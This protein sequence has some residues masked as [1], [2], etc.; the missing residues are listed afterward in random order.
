METP[1]RNLI[2]RHQSG[3]LARISA[4]LETGRGWENYDYPVSLE[5]VFQ[6]VFDDSL[7]EA[8]QVEPVIDD[9][10][11][12]G[13]FLKLFSGNTNRTRTP[14]LNSLANVRQL[15]V[16][17]RPQKK[18]P[19]PV[20]ELQISLPQTAIVTPEITERLLLALASRTAPSALEI[21]GCEQSI[22]V[23][24]AVQESG[25]EQAES[26]VR[27][28]FAESAVVSKTQ[29]YLASHF[30][31]ENGES[32][33]SLIIDFGLKRDVLRPLNTLRSFDPDP[34]INLIGGMSDLKKGEKCI[35]QVLFQ[36]I[37]EH[38]MERFNCL[39]VDSNGKPR[40]A[41]SAELLAES[42]KKFSRPLLAAIIRL[43]VVA[44]NRE[45]ALQIARN[46]RGMLQAV[47]S[48]NGNEVMALDSAGISIE[49]HIQYFIN[50]LSNRSGM[51]LNVA[52]LA[53][54]AHL[55]S[56]SVKI[57]KLKRDEQ[58]TK[59][60]PVSALGHRLIL[61]EN[62]HN[63]QS[64]QV[65]LSNE[66][67]TRHLHLLGGTGS[68]KSNLL[69]NLIKQDLETGEGLC[70]IDP[71]GDLIDAVI[72]N[73]PENRVNDV[74]L[75]DPSDAEFPI[76]FN[77]LQAN[78]EIEKT[79]LS[80]DLVAA[81][82][83]ISTSWGD[84]MDAV[85]A[86]AVLAIVESR[87]GGTLFDLKR[88]LVE[89]DFRN[90][91]LASVE[92]E[93]IRYFWQNEFPLIGG[94][95]QG[96]ILI[97][98]DAFLRQ[99]LV[100]NIVCQ[101]QTRLDF[102][103]IMD[104][105]KVMLV[106]LSQ[107]IIGTENSHLLGTLLV[108]KFHQIALSRQNTTNRP[109]FAL[110]I[111]EFHNFVVPSMESVLSGIRKYNVG[112]HLSHQEFR[113]LQSRSQEVAASVLSNCYTRICFR[114]SETDAERFSHGFSFFDAKSLQNLSIGEAVA[115]IGGADSDFNLKTSLLPLAEKTVAERRKA[116]ILQNTREKYA[117]Q[118]SEVELEITGQR[119]VS[120]SGVAAQPQSNAAEQSG[121]AVEISGSPETQNADF[122]SKAQSFG[123]S[124]KI[125]VKQGRGGR[126]H[127]E[128]QA[129]ISRMAESYGFSAEI[130]KNVLDGAGSIDVSLERENLKI[131][132]EV[133]VTSTAD[134]ETKNV[135]K[136]FS[137]GYDYAVVVVSNQK[138]IP[139][140]NAKLQSE[141]SRE[142]MDKVKTVG[143]TELL[144]FLRE[145]T[146]PEEI[147]QKKSKKPKGQRLN[148]TEACEFFGVGASTLYRWII[149]GRI[150][151]YRPGREYQFDPLELRLVGRHDFSGKRKASVKLEPLKIEKTTPKSKKQQDTRYRKMLKLE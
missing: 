127:Q 113:Q 22:V 89:R 103:E 87:R 27:A 29:N 108:S 62:L 125:E 13:F 150:P 65:T 74:I 50:R 92:D 137:S 18:L 38:W 63:G 23:Q 128:L 11:H 101:K 31:T 109:F 33:H 8:N 133:S 20:G 95:P 151:F 51:L 59:A 34:L 149:Q 90:E 120:F 141:L 142:Q 119:R 30:Q 88:F 17:D 131:A 41:E 14:Q 45:R 26:S 121:H 81:F 135:L 9:G 98:L 86:N 111:D 52:E 15:P 144:A 136:C 69:L 146:A 118:K 5:P 43:G 78:S 60:A 53:S 117:R 104:N 56:A 123:D 138:K 96:S 122:D 107:G 25:I 110:Y 106:K 35:F 68:G 84:V 64:R 3:E 71:H 37:R 44:S 97:R 58:K 1:R 126:H 80:S 40:F 145:L 4:L 115:R 39:L 143:L 93:T 47:S 102:R 10:R 12:P 6:T 72:E 46:L 124:E 28:H 100:R 85:L 7:I 75:F 24:I 32:N 132:C 148:F 114:L 54:L 79:L 77:I 21:I 116:Q 67:R 139:S 16:D 36:A 140:L 99:K 112:L 66:Q 70:A 42:K 129:V 82:K 2:M 94:K 91:F 83:R 130:E 57:E 61:G 76:G 147:S 55:P 48:P 49:T 105:R 73:I 134:Y 19:F